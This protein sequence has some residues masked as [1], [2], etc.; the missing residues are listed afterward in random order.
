M[1]SKEY[2]TIDDDFSLQKIAD[3]GQCFRI[4]TFG[5]VYRFITKDKALYIRNVSENLY[6][7][8]VDREDWNEVWK[9]YFNLDESYKDIG[10][11]IQ[12]NHKYFKDAYE[13]SKGIRILRQD[14]FEVIISFIISQQKSIPQI[15]KIVEDLCCRYGELIETGLENIY[16]FP[17]IEHL[18]DVSSE[19]AF[20]D[21]KLG[22]REKYIL[23]AIK[24]CLSVD[25]EN[26]NKLNDLELFSRLKQFYGVGDKVASCIC[27]YGYH[28]T[29]FVPKDVW[30]NRVI[31]EELEGEDLFKAYG[32]IAGIIQQYV[33]YYK[34]SEGNEI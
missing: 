9:S 16:T 12:D 26:L 20:K 24:E 5:D 32:D 10:S 1:S 7:I 28:R 6:E 2:V 4:K 21:L 13:F 17:S 3:S 23:S 8:S 27:L 34:K 31:E 22:Y 19:E 14:P 25:L 30:I 15:K 33:Y 11:K 18:M 29:G